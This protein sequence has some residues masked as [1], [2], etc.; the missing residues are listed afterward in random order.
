MK[1]RVRFGSVTVIVRVRFEFGWFSVRV[2]FGSTSFTVWVGSGSVRV[3]LMSGSEFPIHKCISQFWVWFGHKWKGKLLLRQNSELSANQW[4]QCT[5]H[6]QSQHSNLLSLK[7]RSWWLWESNPLWR[8]RV[9]FGSFN[10][11]VRFGSGSVGK[12][13]GFVRFGSKWS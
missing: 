12:I 1:V 6:S 2:R 13:F 7:G 9:R 8:V 10:L 3:R 4:H 11:M 5:S